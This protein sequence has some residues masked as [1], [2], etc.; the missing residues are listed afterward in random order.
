MAAKFELKKTASGKFL[1][2][3]KAANGQVVL[4]SE[5]YNAKPSAMKGIAAVR[6][7]SANGKNFDR[8]TDKSGKPY[9]VLL[10]GNRE[11]LGH[12]ESYSSVKSME[13]GIASVQRVAGSAVLSDLAA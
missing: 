8:R 10:A 13:K 12:S 7:A 1:F 6:K 11:P 9:F 5:A 4:T 2:N 3:L